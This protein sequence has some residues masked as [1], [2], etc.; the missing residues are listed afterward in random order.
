MRVVLSVAAVCVGAGLAHAAPVEEAPVT[1]AAGQEIRLGAYAAF[2]SDCS[3]GTA[4]ELRPSG[5]QRGGL[6]IVTAGTLTTSHVPGCSSV[7]APARVLFYRP[8][9]GFTGTDRVT[10]GVVDPATGREQPHSIA[11]TVKP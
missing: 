6:V 7:T 8:N 3:G 1:T 4:A 9:P 10:F 11:V 5:D 2:K